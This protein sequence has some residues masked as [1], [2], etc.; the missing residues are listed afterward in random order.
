MPKLER[1]SKEALNKRC[2]RRSSARGEP[3]TSEGDDGKRPHPPAESAASLDSKDGRINTEVRGGVKKRKVR[4]TRQG[5]DAKCKSSA[6]KKKRRKQEEANDETTEPAATR[7]HSK[8]T[9]AYLTKWY[10]DHN[11]QPY[12]TIAEKGEMATAT[13]LTINQINRWFGSERKRRI[14]AAGDASIPPHSGDTRSH[15]QPAVEY[16]TKWYNNHEMNPY[17]TNAEKEE[18]VTATGL[19]MKQI[20]RWFGSERKRRKKA[21]GNYPVPGSEIRGM[22]PQTAVDHLENWYKQ[23]ESNPFPTKEE[24]AVLISATKLTELQIKQWFIRKR[25]AHREASPMD[26]PAIQANRFFS[27]SNV[28]HL[29]QWYNEHESHPYPQ[30]PDQQELSSVTGLTAKQIQLWFKKE[31]LR[32]AASVSAITCLE[33]WYNEHED[34]P[35]PTKE[36]KGDLASSTGWSERQ[37]SLWF[38]HERT[39]RSKE[40]EGGKLK[41]VL[42]PQAA[43]DYLKGWFKEHESNPYPTKEEKE[44][45]ISCT[46][47]TMRQINRWFNNERT[48]KRAA[49]TYNENED[50]GHDQSIDCSEE[51]AELASSLMYPL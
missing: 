12:P 20:D 7:N 45:M 34:N 29:K 42:H 50:T 40:A 27:Q 30:M 8:S 21:A 17:P 51:E 11:L 19:T 3:A 2:T 38:H 36:E 13:G 33:N 22:L 18:M 37:I 49:R 23:H 39:R 4:A 46:G 41:R 24:K 48:A 32:R 43:V 5:D 1:I 9:V 31:R 47:L 25:R 44:D 15:P 10:N 28:N 6:P 26:A 35:H 14:K 16:L